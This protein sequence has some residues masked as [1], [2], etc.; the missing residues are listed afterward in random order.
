MPEF[1]SDETFDHFFADGF[2]HTAWRLETRRAYESDQRSVGYL[3][4][5]QGE[6]PQADPHRPWCANIREQVAKGKRVE[7]VRIADE[8]ITQGQAY[9]LHV[10]WANVEAGE[11]IRH[12]PRS[13]AKELHLP[14]RDFWL[15]DSRTVLQLH[16]DDADVYLGTELIEDPNVV[17]E[18]CQIRDAAWHFA[19]DRS[20][21]VKKVPSTV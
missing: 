12:L 2:Q 9:L 4:F 6:D 3:R 16:F 8:P 1:I 15:F 19:V 21:F 10:G 11:D 18:A 17:L 7:R 14:E 20:E 5:L 13:T